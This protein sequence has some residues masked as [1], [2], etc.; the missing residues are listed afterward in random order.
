MVVSL[1]NERIHGLQISV[2]ELYRP[3]SILEVDVD[4]ESF[5]SKNLDSPLLYFGTLMGRIFL[6]LQTPIAPPS[7]LALVKSL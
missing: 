7:L 6:K 1:L 2:M 4:F 5:L 3:G